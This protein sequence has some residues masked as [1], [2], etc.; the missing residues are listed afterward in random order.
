MNIFITG[1]AGYVGG[2]LA[3]LLL[4][5]ERVQHITALDMRDGSAQF[6]HDDSR[7]TW[8]THNLGDEGWQELVLRHGRPDV[9]IHCAYVIRQGYGSAREFQNKCNITAAQK[10][11][12]FVF[13][14]GVSRLIHFSTVASYGALPTNT[15]GRQFIETD[16]LQEATYLYGVD[17]KVIEEMLRTVY[18]REVL[19][20]AQHVRTIPL[21]QVIIVRPC[22]ITGPR[23]QHQFRRFG[24]LHMVKN[25]LP[26]IPITGPQSA[27][28]FIHEDDVA[29]AVLH[30]TF[31]GIVGAY[32][33]FNLAPQGYFLLKDM[34]RAIGKRT[35]RIPM[36]LGKLCF[37]LLW[38]LSQGRIPTVPAGINSYTYPIIVDG[39]KLTR[40][41]FH[42]TYTPA[43]ALA[44]QVGRF[45]S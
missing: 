19:R 31:G 37:A 20:L 43:E 15:V 10:I 44:A 30:A 13:T 34:A 42:Y 39:S 9:V 22:A 27:R 8:I 26:I 12:Q 2:M 32:E 40:F 33:I 3:T 6:P 16:P 18:D 11:F 36:L 28:Q 29:D 14:Q 5:D 17:K 4:R 7:L 24:L 41:G 21:P 25:G 35:I 1:A 23:G 45:Q 38:H